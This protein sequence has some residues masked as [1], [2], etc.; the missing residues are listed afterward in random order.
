MLG[1]D[2]QKGHLLVEHAY[3]STGSPIPTAHID[4]NVVLETTKP[5]TLQDGTW[6]NVMGYLRRVASR[7]SM[8][9]KNLPPPLVQAVLIWNAGGIDVEEYEKAMQPTISA[10]RA[11]SDS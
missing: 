3:P 9:H 6:I 11:R 8:N 1:Y 5:S 4:V 7:D 10:L 2:E